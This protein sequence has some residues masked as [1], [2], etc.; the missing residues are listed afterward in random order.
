METPWIGG[1]VLSPLSF[2]NDYSGEEEGCITTLPPFNLLWTRKLEIW[3]Y[4]ISFH[5]TNV[6]ALHHRDT[7][8]PTRMT[9]LYASI[10]CDLFVSCKYLLFNSQE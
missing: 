8:F 1:K 5:R 4:K 3:F 10:A 6:A 7:L 2:F 9:I